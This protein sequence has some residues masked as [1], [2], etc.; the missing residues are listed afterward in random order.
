MGFFDRH[1]FGDCRRWACQQATGKVLEVAVGTGL[2]LAAYPTDI[3]VTGIDWSAQ[4]CDIARHRA[5]PSRRAEPPAD[6][7]QA[8]AHRLPADNGTFDTVVC[9]FGLCAIAHHTQAPDNMT[10]VLR[11]GARLILANHIESTSA[12]IRL[13]QRLREVFTVPI[14]GEHFLR[15]P[16]NHIRAGQLKSNAYHASSSASSNAPPPAKPTSIDQPARVRIGITLDS[17]ARHGSIHGWIGRPLI[18]L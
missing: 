2:N 7:Q 10:R 9:T 13:A 17:D 16:S 18:Y 15:R 12:P 1:V 5:T 11:P 4:M 6:L 3:T 8:G 14:G